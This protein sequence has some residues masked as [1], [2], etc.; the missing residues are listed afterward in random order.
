M[1]KYRIPCREAI[2]L[3]RDAG[4]VAVMAHP[5]LYENG[6]PHRIDDMVLTLKEMGVEGIEVYYP[7]HSPEQVARYE[8]VAAE[9]GLIITGGTDFHGRLKPDIRL[10]TGKGDLSVPY[11]LL[12]PLKERCRS[13]ASPA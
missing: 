5:Y 9:H 2:R 7:E 6:D 13:H 8:Q 3:I 1:D 11:S 10:G 4:G 12:A